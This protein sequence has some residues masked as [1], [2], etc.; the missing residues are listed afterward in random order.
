MLVL[1]VRKAVKC[2][3]FSRHSQNSLS[4]LVGNDEALRARSIAGTRPEERVDAVAIVIEIHDEEGVRVNRINVATDLVM[5]GVEL[6]DKFAPI[7]A[8]LWIL[9]ADCEFK[10]KQKEANEVKFE[11]E[12]WFTRRKAAANFERH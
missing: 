10:S 7:R 5:V 3:S 9:P 11:S 6:S 1:K 4:K 2:R 12:N 8:V